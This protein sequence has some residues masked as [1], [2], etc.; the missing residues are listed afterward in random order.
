MQMSFLMA[1]AIILELENFWLKLAVSVVSDVRLSLKIFSGNLLAGKESVN[2][3]Q[4]QYI[5]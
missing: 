3:N 5:S 2:G 1:G 4:E